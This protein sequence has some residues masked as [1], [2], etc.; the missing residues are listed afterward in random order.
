M[1]IKRAKHRRLSSLTFSVHVEEVGSYLRKLQCDCLGFEKPL[2]LSLSRSAS[3]ASSS[4][5][6]QFACSLLPK[7]ENVA[8]YGLSEYRARFLLTKYF[9]DGWY[10]TS[11]P[12]F[13][14]RQLR[15][16]VCRVN[17]RYSYRKASL[18]NDVRPTL[19]LKSQRYLV[20]SNFLDNHPEVS[21]S[22]VFISIPNYELNVDQLSQLQRTNLIL[23]HR[24]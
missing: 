12:K 4:L 5:N 3:K 9:M 11:P 19:A 10:D 15:E 13:T 23:H 6:V 22:Q 18:L 14:L 17:F 21:W 16:Y 7:N 8:S 1:I 20:T 24:P 2:G